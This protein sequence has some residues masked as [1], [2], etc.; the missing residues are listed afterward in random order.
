MLGW[1]AQLCLRYPKVADALRSHGTSG[2]KH[3]ISGTICLDLTVGRP[4]GQGLPRWPAMMTNELWASPR[5]TF[6]IRRPIAIH[7]Q[8]YLV[9]KPPCSMIVI[10][11]CDRTTSEPKI[12]N[13][14]PAIESP[15]LCIESRV[16]CFERA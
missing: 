10:D 3:S 12:S 9:H 11:D 14:M 7:L 1:S 4:N 16:R 5:K 6:R 15:I 13:P 2:I 8:C